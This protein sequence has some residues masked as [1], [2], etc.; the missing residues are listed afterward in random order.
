M[1]SPHTSRLPADLCEG[2]T[3]HWHPLD[4]CTGCNLIEV[5][6]SQGQELGNSPASSPLTQILSYAP[7]SQSVPSRNETQLPTEVT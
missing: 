7:Q 5:T 4:L 1:V 2:F 3:G 6:L